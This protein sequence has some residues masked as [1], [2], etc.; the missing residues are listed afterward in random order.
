M[1]KDQA[2]SVD[3]TT[4]TL[5]NVAELFGDKIADALR[6]RV[7]KI[8]REELEQLREVGDS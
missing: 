8:V 1:A 3:L 6:E 2:S 4:T 5:A 7:R